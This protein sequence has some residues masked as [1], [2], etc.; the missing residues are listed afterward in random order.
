VD[1]RITQEIAPLF[2]VPVTHNSEGHRQRRAR[3][4]LTNEDL[5]LQHTISHLTCS[6]TPSQGG[7]RIPTIQDFSQN[8]P[9]LRIARED[10]VFDV[11]KPGSGESSTTP[12]V[13]PSAVAFPC[14]KT[15]RSPRTV[16]TAEQDINRC[17]I[18]KHSRPLRRVYQRAC[19]SKFL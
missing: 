7:V 13:Q 3:G 19:L 8:S 12:H 11:S 10:R 18:H 15:K 9:C 2:A 14:P 5:Y 16:Q 6:N 4:L 1:S 17:S